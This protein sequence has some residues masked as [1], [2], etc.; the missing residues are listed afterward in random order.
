MVAHA[1]NPQEAVAGGS[2]VLEQPGLHSE[3]SISSLRYFFIK[4]IWGFIEGLLCARTSVK[5]GFIIITIS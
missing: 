5:V 2:Q 3:A 1:C 4:I